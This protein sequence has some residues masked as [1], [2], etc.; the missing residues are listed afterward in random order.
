MK[1]L[2][3]MEG[4]PVEIDEAVRLPSDLSEWVAKAQLREWIA[5]RVNSFDWENPELEKILRQQPEFEPRALL[6]AAA[7]AYLTGAFGAEEIVRACSRDPEFKPIRPKLPPRAEEFSTFRKLNRALIQE[8]LQHV[9]V[10]ALWTQCVDG[11]DS[12][13]LPA[14]LQ[15][16]VTQNAMERLNIARHMDRAQAA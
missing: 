11:N 3:V 8:V 1:G 15:R 14:G 4:P 9:I 7:L 16:M 12:A 13:I 10:K 2:E 5:E 6:S